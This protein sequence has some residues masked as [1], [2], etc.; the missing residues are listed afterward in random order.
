MERVKNVVVKNARGHVYFEHGQPTFG[1]PDHVTVGPLA[2]LN[3]E[4]RAVFLNVDYGSVW[5]EV[6][7]RMMTRLAVGHDL[8]KNNWVVVQPGIYRYAV[9]SEG[10]F[11]VGAILREYLGRCGLGAP[12]RRPRPAQGPPSTS[13]CPRPS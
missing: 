9:I 13:R 2:V 10:R 4:Q 6:G 11:V 3:D 5:P 12:A 1:E 7:S 8:D